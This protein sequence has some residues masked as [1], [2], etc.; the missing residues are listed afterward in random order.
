MGA[1][2]WHDQICI[3]TVPRALA[4]S[5]QN[6]TPAVLRKGLRGPGGA[7]TEGPSGFTKDAS[8][9]Q[10][11]PQRRRTPTQGCLAPSVSPQLAQ[12]QALRREQIEE[13]VSLLGKRPGLGLPLCLGHA[14][15]TLA[16]LAQAGRAASDRAVAQNA[17]LPGPEVTVCPQHLHL[18][19][20]P[21]C[22]F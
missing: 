6:V 2:G 19:C 7:R 17:P 10:S 4:S 11:G 3:Q 12:T 8:I 1:G 9:T 18:P 13:E 14:P 21:T 5:L 15:S 16:L 20:F 22:H